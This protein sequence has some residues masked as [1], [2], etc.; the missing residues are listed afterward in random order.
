MRLHIFLSLKF[1]FE[2]AGLSCLLFYALTKKWKEAVKATGRRWYLFP[3]LAVIQEYLYSIMG[4]SFF[5]ILYVVWNI[6]ALWLFWG[7]E[8]KRERNFSMIWISYSVILFQ[9]CQMAVTCLIFVIPNFATHLSDFGSSEELLST[10]LIWLIGGISAIVSCY[11]LEENHTLS[12]KESLW[13]QFFLWLTFLAEY[14]I[15]FSFTDSDMG[16][17]LPVLIFLLLYMDIQLYFFSFMQSMHERNRRIEEMHIRQH[18]ANLLQHYEEINSLYR[19]LREVRHDMN[20][21]ILYMDR[22]L[23]DGEYEALEKYFG[24]TKEYLSPALEM[25]DYGNKLVNAI[26]WSKEDRARAEGIEM[27]VHVSLPEEVNVESYHL[28]SLVGNLLDNA[29]EGSKDVEKPKITVTMRIKERYLFI[30][31]SNKVSEDI[32]EINP[33]FHSTKGD[34]DEHGYGIRIIRKIA[35]QYDGMVDFMVENGEFR[36][37]VML[38]IG[39]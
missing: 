34:N 30:S 24:K 29:I 22:L 19:K 38:L 28:C 36:A 5:S 15:Y 6:G 10:F 4:T 1:M 23:K 17:L 18:Y 25:K 11:F 8:I 27:E 13:A 33:D 12:L 39:A 20:N 14:L 35:E 26:L 31:V 3:I 32:L 2:T 9:L 37:S 16:R 7:L 21:Q